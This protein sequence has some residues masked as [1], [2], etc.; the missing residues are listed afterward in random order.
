MIGPA[1][2][3]ALLRTAREAIESY[4]CGR[5]VSARTAS[6]EL[7]QERGAFVTLR[8]M[9]ELRGCIGHVEA[10][11]PLVEVVARCAISAATSDPRF[12]VVA[13]G[14]IDA[15]EIEISVLGQLEA[16]TEPAGIEIGR[17]GLLVE[18]GW[19]RGLLLPQVAAERHWDPLTF[20]QQTC[21]KAGLGPSGWQK[22]RVWRF[23]ADVF[24]ETAAPAPP[25]HEER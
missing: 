22:A 20:L 6:A 7:L 25:G 21:V 17:H 4:L 11:E 3:A 24:S 14:E 15:L 23:T 8:K 1:D 9:G 13:P 2:R 10:D 16:L 5:A 18:E 12:P 19:R